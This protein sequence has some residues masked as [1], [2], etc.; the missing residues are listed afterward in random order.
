MCV[1]G[2]SSISFSLCY[3]KTKFSKK[4]EVEIMSVG[5]TKCWE[6]QEIQHRKAKEKEGETNKEM[7]DDC[8]VLQQHLVYLIF[9]P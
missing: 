5:L 6:V 7:V 1:F 3:M 9:V 2:N 8:G 4:L